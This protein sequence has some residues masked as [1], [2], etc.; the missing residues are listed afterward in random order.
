MKPSS[1]SIQDIKGQVTELTWSY[2]IWWELSYVQNRTRFKA[3]LQ[4]YPNFFEA[5]RLSMEQGFC[6]TTYRLFDK[7][8][9]ATSL[10]KLIQNLKKSDEMLA[11]QLGSRIDANKELLKKIQIIRQNVYGHR[12]E[13]LSPKDAYQKARLKPNE[14]KAILL[15]VQETAAALAEAAGTQSKDSSLDRFHHCE[16]DAKDEATLILQA[17]ERSGI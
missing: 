16:S 10:I 15:L 2:A 9:R 8:A 5:V 7:E 11:Q 17:L 12:N 13:K 1:D 4:A 14:M 3:V 6:V